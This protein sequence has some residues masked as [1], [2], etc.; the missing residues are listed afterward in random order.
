MNNLV[1]RY[2]QWAL[3]T[4]AARAI[5]LGYAFA[6]HL[7]Q[8]GMNI[9]IVDIL[10]EELHERVQELQN[11]YQV[12]ARG[13]VLD[14]SQHDFIP[15]LEQELG[16]IEIGL[17]I[18]NHAYALKDMQEFVHT[19]PD[20]LLSMLYI[21]SRAYTLLAHTFSNKMVKQGRG[22]IIFVSS[23]A[24]V[25]STP[26]VGAYSANK[27]YQRALGEILWY[28][29]QG[30]GVEV[31]VVSPGLMRTQE[32]ILEDYPDYLVTETSFVAKNALDN[33]GKKP[34]IIPGIVNKLTSFIQSHFMSRGGAVKNIG[35][36]MKKSTNK[37]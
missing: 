28:E 34:L 27:A 4:G 2:G 13:I 35:D 23:R 30:T 5:G 31:L 10:E 29:L 32:G 3:I 37:V 17:L 6:K 7:A 9:V 18:C 26:Y 24:G 25:I 11:D 1:E 19:S 12:E 36:V 22:G 33:L 14:F 15:T 20:S 16:G 21:N 8:A